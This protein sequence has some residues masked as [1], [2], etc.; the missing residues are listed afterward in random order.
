MKKA[1]SYII[2]SIVDDPE[3]VDITETENEGVINFTVSVAKED[4]GKIIGKGGKVIKAV[5]NVIKIPAIKQNK[6]IY[7]SLS[8]NPQE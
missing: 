3:K 4:M 2:S 8:E 5:R 7:I 1:L 6:K